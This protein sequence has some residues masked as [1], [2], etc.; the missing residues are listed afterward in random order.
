LDRRSMELVTRTDCAD[1][2]IA[3]GSANNTES[4]VEKG[5]QGG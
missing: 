3:L 1:E 2:A 4:G 5:E